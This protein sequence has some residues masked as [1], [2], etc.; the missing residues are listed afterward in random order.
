MAIELEFL[1][2]VVPVQRIKDLYRGGWAAYLADNQKRLGKILWHDLDLVHACGA[3]DPEM[4]DV[5]IGNFTSLGFTATE[6][7]DGR[8]V[9]RDFCV[10]NAF[11][12]SQHQCPWLVVDGAARIAWMRGT[13]PGVVVGREHM[14]SG[15]F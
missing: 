1:N 4:D 15:G 2:L 8:T 13:E 7:V 14:R 11:G 12:I 9:W 5:L 3:M 10:L 6:V